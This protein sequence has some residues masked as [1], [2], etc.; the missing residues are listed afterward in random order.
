MRFV[1]AACV[2]AALLAG[3]KSEPKITGV[4]IVAQF[5]SVMIDQL[6]FRLEVTNDPKQRDPILRPETRGATLASSQDLVVYLPDTLAGE[7]AT[8]RVT[9]LRQGAP[10]SRG[11]P[12]TTR[13]ELHKVVPCVIVA[14]EERFGDAGA[15]DAQVVVLSDAG[16]PVDGTVLPPDAATV[17]APL[18]R[19][20]APGVD[21]PP[22]ADSAPPTDLLV[23][24][25]DA[26]PDTTAPPPDL[27]PPPD[28]APVT[29]C[30]G[31]APRT[32]F[33]SIPQFP[34]IASCGTPT[35]YNEALGRGSGACASGWHWCKAEEVS[36][37]PA[38]PPGMVPGSTCS[39]L[40]G[41]QAT[42]NDR[43]TA[44]ARASC[45]GPAGTNAS[46]GGAPTGNLPCLGG[47]IGCMEPWKLAVSFDRWES[48]S[49]T[50]MGG[51]CLEH[52]DL[53]CTSMAGGASCWITC[54]KNP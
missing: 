14:D 41:T 39:W 54:C 33:V 19:D 1:A 34:A 45:A 49:V 28:T 42:C 16:I 17:D 37:L 51:G 21:V 3:C 22:P 6:E 38:D 31:N 48:N 24:P 52:L 32:A 5:S 44:Y 43:R 20:V 35:S 8:C 7:T 36:G 4:R 10:A 47:A 27:A 50:G 15:P 18:P 2:A 11:I 30:A 46:I 25:P 53:K 26:P 9:G 13:V 12:R 29:G 23:V 40:D